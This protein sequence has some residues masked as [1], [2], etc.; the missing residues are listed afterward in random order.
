MPPA[1]CAATP[2]VG[3]APRLA[4]PLRV[5]G[6]GHR[7]VVGL[8]LFAAVWLSQLASHSLAPPMDTIEQLTWVQSLEWGYYKHPPL[9]TWL[10][11]LPVKLFG[12]SPWAGYVVGAAC[13]LAALGLM[14]R[15]L[16]QLRGQSHATVAL[17]AA[18]C[19]TYY[20]GRLDDYNHNVVL[21]LLSAASA[22]ACW[23]AFATRRWR[24]WLGLG[25][26]I[27][28]G[29]LAKYQ[30]AVTIASVLAFA[31]HQRAWRDA[32]HRRG[33]LLACLVALVVFAP[34]AVWL[35]TNDF[36]PVQYAVESSLGAGLNR[37]DRMAKSAHWLV[38]QLFNRA[39][40]AWIL[41]AIAARSRVRA[42]P[43]TALPSAPPVAAPRDAARALLL[44]WGLVPLLFMP[45]AGVV[46]GADLQLHWGT[47]FLLF[48]VPALMELRPRASW[49]RIDWRTTWAAFVIIQALLLAFNHV[50]SPRGI[51][52]LGHGQWRTFDAAELARLVA[53]PAR[54]E[55]GGPIRIVSGPATAAGAL[56]L[57]LPER[58]LVLIDGRHDRSP[59]VTPALVRRCGA[60]QLGPKTALAASH[61]LGAAFPELSWNV[62]ERDPAAAPCPR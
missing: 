45:L 5:I 9:P 13:T 30:V 42:A 2:W 43:G 3:W 38:D 47:P 50:T 37:V 29:A 44:S 49:Q 40:P 6:S 14:W 36:A 51:R 11:W 56:A 16:A 52:S 26:A 53:V 12:P 57:Q 24:W 58:P 35:W 46:S 17:L 25:L 10:L 48:A 15:L 59:W 54:R 4:M 62:V 1:V 23:Q 18:L 34:H 33:A 31:V 22:A 39:L 41:L 61:A 8:L 28:L 55:I 19:I 20:T 32:Q 21:M 60:L 7:V 27:G